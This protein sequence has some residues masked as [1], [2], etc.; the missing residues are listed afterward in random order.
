MKA[1]TVYL[2]IIWKFWGG[3]LHCILLW[4]D[5][6]IL[7]VL[8]KNILFL[9]KCFKIFFLFLRAK[10]EK[11][12]I[13]FSPWG[14]KVIHFISVV[15]FSTAGSTTEERATAIRAKQQGFTLSPPQTHLLPNKDLNLS[16]TSFSTSVKW[17]WYL[18]HR[19]VKIKWGN[20]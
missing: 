7:V 16:W 19:V 17:E 15:A 11:G 5:L 14:E 1:T 13:L 10:V 3:V 8:G 12:F 4:K 6:S 9:K 2:F 18:C 20:S